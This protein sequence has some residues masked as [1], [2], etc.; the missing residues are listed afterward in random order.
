LYIDN[1]LLI[2]WDEE[3][4]QAFSG[5]IPLSKGFYPFRIEY[6]RQH[7]DCKLAF[8]YLTPVFMDIQAI[9]PIPFNLQYNFISK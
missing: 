8:A 5:I 4:G 3:C 7:E 2:T 6:L 1:K 9:T